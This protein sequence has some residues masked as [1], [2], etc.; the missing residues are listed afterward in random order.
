MFD[1]SCKLKFIS[2]FLSMLFFLSI[3]SSY[4]SSSLPSKHKPASGLSVVNY[5][6]NLTLSLVDTNFRGSWVIGADNRDTIEQT[7]QKIQKTFDSLVKVKIG[8]NKEDVRKALNTPQEIKNNGRIWIYGTSLQD[9]TYK[10]LTQVFFDD[11]G[12]NV[13]AVTSFNSKSILENL[14]IGI[15]D[16]IEKLISVFGEPVD[17]KDFIEDPDNKNY[18]GLYY[19]YPR[20]GIGF[21]LGQDKVTNSLLVQG[22]LVFGK[23]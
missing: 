2:I 12:E 17:E 5:A 3:T 14:G 9:G 1:K 16:S 19:L 20:S 23:Y 18:M 15:G 6:R 22:V 13:I 8:S 7:T 21:L 11:K 4:S 10:D